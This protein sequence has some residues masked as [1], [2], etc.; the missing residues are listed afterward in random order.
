MFND[1]N[2]FDTTA[3]P[4][5]I[6][7]KFNEYNAENDNRYTLEINEEKKWVKISLEDKETPENDFLVKV[8]FF[9][10]PDEVEGQDPRY[11]VKF[12]RKRGNYM[13]WTDTFKEV[14]ETAFDGY[15]IAT[16]NQ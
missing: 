3:Q 8:K 11:R 6:V 15:F 12:A 16:Q 13:N 1:N 7:E 4:G 9:K 5:E 10:L 2:E 14:R